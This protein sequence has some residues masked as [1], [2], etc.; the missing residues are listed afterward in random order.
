MKLNNISRVFGLLLGTV[1]FVSAPAVNAE[2][3]RITDINGR[4]VTVDLPVKRAVLGFYYQDYMAIGGKEA[5]NNV[6]GFSKAVWADWAPASWEA[7]SKAV[8]ELNK[9]ADVGEVEVGT[10]S[11]EKVLSLKPDLLLLADWQY[12]ALGSDLDRLEKAGIPIVVVDYN[13]QT[14]EKHMKSTEIIG[15]LTGRKEQAAKLA[16]EY[17]AVA[18]DIQSRIAKANLP[19][20]KVYVEFGNKGPEEHSV[21]FGKAMWGPMITLAGGENISAASVE[22]YAPINPEQVLAAKPDVIVVTGRETELK[23]NPAAMVMGWGISRSEAEARLAGFAKRQG[24]DALPAVRN[25]RLYGA[26]HANSRTLSDGAS[27]QFMAKAV[28][29]QLFSDLDPEKTYRDFYRNYLP[30]VPE[31]VFY[32]QEGCK[33]LNCVQGS[34]GSTTG[35]A[36]A[37]S[38]W[39]KL[40]A[41]FKALF[42]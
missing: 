28:Y 34:A 6:V 15:M 37:D 36:A 24:W 10:F 40:V 20:P 12:Q 22:F 3:V 17:K 11:I 21:T 13:A 27:L 18:D 5:L 19:K 35:D 31:G 32:I 23:K 14:V 7:F 39:R 2:P 9:L 42:G 26:Y 8:P 38:W 4:E 41:W 30:V 29:P 33:D 16:G 1:M 25:K